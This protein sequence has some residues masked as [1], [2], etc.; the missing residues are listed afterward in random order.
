MGRLSDGVVIAAW[1]A[2]GMKWAWVV[3][4]VL[5]LGAAFLMVRGPADAP[6]EPGASRNIEEASS[7]VQTAPGLQGSGKHVGASG[8]RRETRGR[9]V[10]EAGQPVE[11]AEVRV[12][13]LV[14]AFGFDAAELNTPPEARATTA[15]DGSFVVS[16]D[17]GLT[18]ACFSATAGGRVTSQTEDRLPR[19][20]L[21]LALDQEARYVTIRAVTPEAVP[22]PRVRLYMGT[23]PTGRYAQVGVTD[24]EG[25]V[26]FRLLDPDARSIWVMAKPEGVPRRWPELFELDP[27]TAEQTHVLEL[28]PGR[29]I[30]GRVVDAKTGKPQSGVWVIHPGTE[31]RIATTDAS[32]LYEVQGFVDYGLGALV[33]QGPMHRRSSFEFA[34]GVEQPEQRIHR[35][36]VIRG[37]FGGRIERGTPPDGDGDPWMPLPSSAPAPASAGIDAYA[38]DEEGKWAF[39]GRG[40]IEAPGRFMVAVDPDGPSQVELSLVREGP[41]NFGPFALVD[42]GAKRPKAWELDLGTVAIEPAPE[43]HGRVLGSDGVGVAGVRLDLWRVWRDGVHSSWSA[44]TQTDAEGRFSFGALLPG[45]WEVRVDDTPVGVEHDAKGTPWTLR[46]PRPGGR[47][48]GVLVQVVTPTGD[49]VPR[50][51][52]L[53]AEAGGGVQRRLSNSQ[54]RASFTLHGLST[55]ILVQSPRLEIPLAKPMDLTGDE[56]GTIVLQTYPLA[57]SRLRIDPPEAGRLWDVLEVTIDREGRDPLRYW[58]KSHIVLQHPVGWRGRARVSAR[59]LRSGK[60][61]IHTVEAPFGSAG[62]ELLLRPEQRPSETAPISVQ[63]LRPDGDPLARKLVLGLHGG[64]HMSRSFSAGIGGDGWARFEGVPVGGWLVAKIDDAELIERGW[65]LERASFRVEAGRDTY[66]LSLSA[67]RVLRGRV[68][69]GQHAGLTME[70]V[71]LRQGEATLTQAPVGEDGRFELLAPTEAAARHEDMPLWVEYKALS[72][73][74]ISTVVSRVWR[75]LDGPLVIELPAFERSG[76]RR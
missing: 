30:A 4:A 45:S 22:V 9:V 21:R 52:V 27:T 23:T 51:T 60:V 47:E 40:D 50:A 28:A 42:L 71:V 57:T 41:S 72:R 53:L 14:P 65:R 63:V 38:S 3:V 10:D 18:R 70:R 62:G 58:Q 16:I 74:G 15:A 31:E 56:E 8:P 11:G 25:Q 46:L 33:L 36:L 1:F 59:L 48:R 13:R 24:G 64:A 17:E 2:S 73:G 7:E 19:E 44:Y 39:A 35:G 55:Q 43:A 26:R 76:A 54:G 29:H 5:V 68:D 32:G 66:T 61:A 67:S 69:R 34:D 12:D 49:P 20:D 6:S 37:V 75:R